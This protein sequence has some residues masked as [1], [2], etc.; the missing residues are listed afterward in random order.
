MNY[1]VFLYKYVTMNNLYDKPVYGEYPRFKQILQLRPP[2]CSFPL[3][4]ILLE[5]A[6]F[7]KMLLYCLQG[8]IK[9]LSMGLIDKTQHPDRNWILL[10]LLPVSS[11]HMALSMPGRKAVLP[12]A[13]SMLCCQQH[14]FLLS[15]WKKWNKGT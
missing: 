10:P 5:L 1:N 14:H 4:N 15:A 3:I 6:F 11:F 7:W 12:R 9:D 2:K 8:N 13:G